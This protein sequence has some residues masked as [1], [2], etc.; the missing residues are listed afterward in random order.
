MSPTSTEILS[1]SNIRVTGVEACTS[2]KQHSPY[3]SDIRIIMNLCHALNVIIHQIR[4]VTMRNTMWQYTNRRKCGLCNFATPNTQCLQRHLQKEHNKN[5]FL[6]F[7]CHTC[8]KG[9]KF[10]SVLEIHQRIHSGIRPFKCRY[11]KAKS[12][13][14]DSHECHSCL[15][16][17]DTVNELNEHNSNSH[18]YKCRF[19]ELVFTGY[20]KRWYHEKVRHIDH[21]INSYRCRYCPKK[22]NTEEEKIAHGRHSE[23][24]SSASCKGMK[25]NLQRHVFMN[26]EDASNLLPQKC[27]ICHKIFT[28]VH[29]LDKHQ[30]SHPEFRP[31]KCRFCDNRFT[32]IQCLN[33]H[34]KFQHI[35]Q[36]CHRCRHCTKKFNTEQ[37]K[38]EHEQPSDPNSIAKCRKLPSKAPKKESSKSSM[39]IKSGRKSVS[40]TAKA[41]SSSTK[42]D[43]L[44]SNVLTC[45]DCNEHFLSKKVLLK[46]TK[47]CVF[48]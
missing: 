14:S 21:M 6:P 48:A 8:K 40:A 37:E 11:I 28:T 45:D 42:T 31:F 44:A 30:G 7:Q 13:G 36:K 25:S 38:I 33:T 10:M 32:R 39:K 29:E 18:T 12:N 16:H 47:Y 41:S 9:F 17:F 23:S 46:H 5:S 35:E 27:S 15:I 43:P 26:N 3:I 34:E 22:F 4:I 1:V 19:C 24:E 2:P 20:H